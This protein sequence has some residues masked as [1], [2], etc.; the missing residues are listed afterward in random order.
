MCKSCLLCLRHIIYYIDDHPRYNM[1]FT[2]IDPYFQ[3]NHVLD[4]HYN[5]EITSTYCAPGAHFAANNICKCKD[6]LSLF[7][8][9]RGKESTAGATI[10]INIQQ[11]DTYNN[12]NPCTKSKVSSK[13]YLQ[14][15]TM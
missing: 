12:N 8:L 9:N 6:L 1:S 14:K 3:I 10:H 5:G 11:H 2:S 4:S 13:S 7:R 15:V